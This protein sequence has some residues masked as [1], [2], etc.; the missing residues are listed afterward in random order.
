MN[1]TT[2]SQAFVDHL[3]ARNFEQ[4]AGTLA[5]DAVAR[6]LLPRGPQETAGADAIARRF[7]GWFGGAGSFTVLSTVNQQVGR[8]SML[9]WRFSLVRDGQTS[10]IIEQV[11]FVDVGPAGIYR[12]DLLCSGFLPD[13]EALACDVTPS[14]DRPQS[15]VTQQA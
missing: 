7:E 10:E 3:A 5:P 12:L 11:A 13:S 9:Q 8:R 15:L 2:S 6:F 1:T 4:L 14:G